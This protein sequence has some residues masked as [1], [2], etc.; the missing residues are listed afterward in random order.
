LCWPKYAASHGWTVLLRVKENAALSD[1]PIVVFSTSRQ[2]EGQERP[3]P[4]ARDGISLS[5]TISLDSTIESFCADF[6]P[7]AMG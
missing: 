3:L 2:L 7:Q 6:L 4:L 5:L 1:I